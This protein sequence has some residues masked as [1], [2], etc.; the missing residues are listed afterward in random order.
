MALALGLAVPTNFYF[1]TRLPSQIRASRGSTHGRVLRTFQCMAVSL[2]ACE[3]KIVRRSA[4]YQPTIWDY[5]YV[6]SLNSKYAGDAYAKQAT[7]L[8]EDV[9]IM[10]DKVVDP[11]VG[12]EMID[13]LQRLGVFY[14][15]EE[16]IKRVLEKV[17]D[18]F[19]NWSKEDLHA[20]ALKFRLMRQ[21]GYNIDQDNA[22]AVALR[23]TTPT[24]A[25]VPSRLTSQVKSGRSQVSHT[26]RCIG[27]SL[28]TT[29]EKIVRRSANYQ[30]SIWDYDYVQSLNSKYVG[31]MY[32]RQAAKLK[33]DVKIMLNKVV[34]PLDGFEMIDD[35]QRLGLFYH[36]E[37]EIKRVL[38]SLYDNKFDKWNKDDLHVTALKFRLL[39]QHGYDVP[40]A[41]IAGVFNPF[42]DESGDFKACLGEDVKGM[43]RLYEASYLSIEGES[44]LEEARDFATKNLR[45]WLKRKDIHHDLAMLVSHALELPLHWRVPRLEARWFI[46]VY[47]GRPD[48]NPTLLQLAKLDYNIV[49]AIHQADLKH[50]S[51]PQFGYRRRAA[52]IVNALITVIDDTYDVYGT[53]DELEL[54]T[55]AVERWDITAMEQL[56][57]YM[58]LCFLSL[59]N[60]INEMGYKSLKDQ[61]VHCI[62]YLQKMW[63]DLCKAYLVEA[64]WYY[65]RYTPTFEEYMNNSCISIA[66]PVMLTHAYFLSTNP[67][68]MEGLEWLEKYP[69][70]VRWSATILRLADD[71]GTSSDEMKRGDTPKSIQCYMHET[72]ASEEEAR[73]HIKY[74]IGEAWKKMNK[75]QCVESPCSQ[76]FVEIAMNLGR[77]AQCMYQYGDGHGAQGVETKDRVLS[78]LINP[79]PLA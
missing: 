51:R 45:Q 6:Q 47:E 63:A 11:L 53:L 41:S 40:Q 46:D 68:T 34:D 26:V 17:N 8:K 77:M 19:D 54:F 71:L 50:A 76:I 44:T 70:I 62:P 27:V 9:K 56:P 4:N 66:T 5:D 73:E 42:K 59:F 65:N 35:L 22:M 1:P 55:D 38:E 64:K 25:Y 57:Y 23:I 13:D 67:I 21:H 10:L 69:N 74:L 18:S 3:Q 49:Q 75:D 43:L 36:F 7:N 31:D 37:D 58:K 48:M 79:V 12:L 52:T 39:R 33:E 16:E 15:F 24:S 14:H 78:L 32:A 60:S 20:I 29:N 28:K 61:G 30:P 72:G 2:Q